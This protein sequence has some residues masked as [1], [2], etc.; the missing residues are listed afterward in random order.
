[1]MSRKDRNVT[2]KLAIETLGTEQAERM[3]TASRLHAGPLR[4]IGT[5]ARTVIS[6][7]RA[8]AALDADFTRRQAFARWRGLIEEITAAPPLP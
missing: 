2:A 3:A 8:R 6:R 1:M 4:W 5:S 7:C